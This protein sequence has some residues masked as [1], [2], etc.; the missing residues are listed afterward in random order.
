MKNEGLAKFP[1]IIGI[2]FILMM[3]Q[4]VLNL[5]VVSTILF[6]ALTFL[7]VFAVL[8]IFADS[9][10][11][12]YDPF[13][14]FFSIVFSFMFLFLAVYVAKSFT[15]VI[16][17]VSTGIVCGIISF[18]FRPRNIKNKFLQ[19][20]DEFIKNVKEETDINKT[21][22]IKVIEVKRD[23]K[24]ILKKFNETKI[25]GIMPRKNVIEA[26]LIYKPYYY[27][28]GDT[29]FERKHFKKGLQKENHTLKVMVDAQNRNTFGIEDKVLNYGLKTVS[30]THLGEITFDK[31]IAYKKAENLAKYSMGMSKFKRIL[32]LSKETMD[33]IYRPFWVA[34]FEDGNY[35]IIPA[36]NFQVIKAKR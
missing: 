35:S 28:T 11:G 7:I 36:D 25:L 13:R 8:N 22:S 2:I 31:K 19:F 9:R 15:D 18:I 32:D 1:P 4:F 17:G 3:S 33:I 12:Q 23:K 27:F 30:E 20:S 14:D 16:V 29:T 21:Q 24:E 6:T 26:K 10:T 34:F 5:H